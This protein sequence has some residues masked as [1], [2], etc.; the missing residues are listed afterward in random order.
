MK[1]RRLSVDGHGEILYG[2]APTSEHLWGWNY[3]YDNEFVNE[4]AFLREE[5]LKL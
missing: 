3:F 2:H 5:I 4:K 1:R